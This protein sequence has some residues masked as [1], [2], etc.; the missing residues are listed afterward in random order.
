LVVCKHALRNALIAVVTFIGFMFGIVIASS[1]TTET[2]FV[3]PGIGRLVYE[4]SLCSSGQRL[5]FS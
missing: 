3:W 5:L 4:A 1:I 2:V